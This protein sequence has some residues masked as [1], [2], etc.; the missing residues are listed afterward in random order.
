MRR[1][2][3]SRRLPGWR[4][5]ALV[6]LILASGCRAHAAEAQSAFTWRARATN[7]TTA[8]EPQASSVFAAPGA[9]DAWSASNQF[10]ASGDGTWDWRHRVKLG[11]GVDLLA[12]SDD[13]SRLRAREAY[14]RASLTSWLDVEGGK[15][16]LRWGTGYGFTPTGLLDP[17]R[18]ATDPQDHLGLNEGMVLVRAD[19]FRG[20]TAVTIAAAAP[21]LNRDATTIA[22]PRR[23]L[24]LRVRTAI[25]GVELAAVAA[26]TD[27]RRLSWGANFTHV[28]GRRLEY[29]GELLVH[30]DESAWRRLLVP[31]ESRP[32]EVSGLV[33]LQYT[34]DLGL[35]L[36]VEYYHDGNGLSS[37]LWSR[38]YEGAERQRMMDTLV[39]PVAA[40]V[41]PA[42]G[43]RGRPTRRNL[44]FLRGSTA[45]TD[46]VISPAWISIFS[47][48]DGGVTLVPTLTIA[49]TRRLQ[50][51]GRAVAL[52]GR[53]RSADATAPI[54]ATI[55]AGMTVLF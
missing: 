53:A 37:S 11:A 17:P 39:G 14:A 24:A 54:T 21:R 9:S 45:N 48:D 26:A 29:H 36:I 19:A 4:R 1:T 15:R 27:H 38:L 12:P 22:A 16:L 30:D 8:T 10:I 23:L 50:V 32:R 41:P 49:P 2:D 3:V 28:I 7:E 33:G 44:L 20:A 6:V 5:R 42:A 40:D 25:A 34:M 18:S 13:R 31:G 43:P 52:T 55:S 51:Y 35:N 47:L 46:A